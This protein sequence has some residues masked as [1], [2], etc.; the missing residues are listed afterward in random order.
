MAHGAMR[1]ELKAKR[2]RA[3]FSLVEML[4]TLIVVGLVGMAVVAGVPA[5]Q[6]AYE[7][8]MDASNA[9][10]MVSTAT[11]RLRDVLAVAD[12]ATVQAGS[13]PLVE[14]TSF[15]T[16]LKTTLKNTDEGLT[17]VEA[18]PMN[19]SVKNEALIVPQAAGKGA[20]DYLH[21]YIDT[22]GDD[23]G[24]QFD[25]NTGLF[26]IKGIYVTRSGDGADIDKALAKV[27]PLSIRLLVPLMGSGS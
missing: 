7:A 11:T 25:K 14:F 21:V 3:G 4:A 6:R 1:T 17:L 20:Q 22:K 8:A 2:A 19:P 12:S 26:T 23:G 27:G 10:L 15:E 18:D 16:G 13:D 9:Q 5:A 24:I